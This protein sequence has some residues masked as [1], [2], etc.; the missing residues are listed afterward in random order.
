MKGDGTRPRYAAKDHRPTPIEARESACGDPLHDLSFAWF[1]TILE[2]CNFRKC[3][4]ESGNN[5][6]HANGLVVDSCL[7]TFRF[8]FCVHSSSPP[9]LLSF[10]DGIPLPPLSKHVTAR[11][12][13]PSAS[14]TD[15][16]IF[17]S[18][19]VNFLCS[20]GV[21]LHMYQKCSS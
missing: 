18:P 9:R 8:Q 2:L 4:L 15:T 14:I 19:A 10:P 13:I 3:T 16:S 21:E 7:N 12:H 6:S 5:P 17:L 11:G 1:L 20:L